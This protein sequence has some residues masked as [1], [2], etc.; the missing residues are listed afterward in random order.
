MDVFLAT[1]RYVWQYVMATQRHI[2]QAK[3]TRD[4]ARLSLKVRPEFLRASKIPPKLVYVGKN[5]SPVLRALGS[6]SCTSWGTFL[7]S[8]CGG[9][10]SVDHNMPLFQD[11]TNLDRFTQQILTG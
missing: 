4:G 7:F 3:K 11:I 6:A 10:V 5:H 9:G 2:I 1:H 8:F